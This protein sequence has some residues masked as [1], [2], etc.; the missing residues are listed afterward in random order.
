MSKCLECNNEYKFLTWKHLRKHNLTIKEYNEKWKTNEKG[1]PYPWKDKKPPYTWKK[2][3][4]PW[5][6][7]LTKETNETLKQMSEDRMGE[8]NPVHK[9]KDKEQWGENI[10]KALKG[11]KR[12]TLEQ[13]MGDEKATELRKR[14]SNSAK[15]RKVHGHTGHKHTEESKNIQRAKTSARI[16]NGEFSKTSKVQLEFYEYIKS[17]YNNAELNKQIGYYTVDVFIEPNICIEFDGDYWH[18]NPEWMKKRG[19]T[20][21]SEV[22]NKNVKNQKRKDS[23]LK[24]QNYIVIRIWES[25]FKNN[26]EEV[27]NKIKGN[28]NVNAK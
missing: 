22:Q 27:I 18:A 6:T 20:R 12:G 1:S 26:K 23:Y 16:A 2:G 14:L 15:K 25:D 17:F 13:I 8:N 5:N 11:K 4:K 21:L 10:R 9:V 7:G 28:A 3:N 24:N 19:H